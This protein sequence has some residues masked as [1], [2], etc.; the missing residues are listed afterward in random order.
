MK[1]RTSENSLLTGFSKR[2]N[3]FICCWYPNSSK[4][5]YFTGLK[6]I[7]MLAWQILKV[8]KNLCSSFFP[9]DF[10]PEASLPSLTG[11][12]DSHMKCQ[13]AFSDY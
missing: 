2:V 8:A 6:A 4:H 1:E 13:Q 10:D 5:D 7:Q 11:L 9:F 3:W 12:S